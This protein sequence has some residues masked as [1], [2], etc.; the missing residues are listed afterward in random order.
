[1]LLL[2]ILRKTPFIRFLLFYIT[3]IVFAK[4]TAFENLY[5][6]LLCT[7]ILMIIA[8][9]ILVWV[10]AYPGLIRLRISGIVA[11]L[12]LFLSG[13]LVMQVH[14][15][16][17]NKWEKTSGYKGWVV[18]EVNEPP[19]FHKKSVSVGV[20]VHYWKTDLIWQKHQQKLMAWFFKDSSSQALQTGQM[21]IAPVVFKSV[22]NKEKNKQQLIFQKYLNARSIYNYVYIKKNSWKLLDQ[23]PQRDLRYFS[24]KTQQQILT[25][26]RQM[27]LSHDAFGILS[28]ITMGYKADVEPET[29]LLFTKAG[30]IHIM[31]LSGFNVAI[32]ALFLDYLLFFA[33][34]RTWGKW[35]RS[36]VTIAFIWLFAF[37]TG[38]S[39]SV[40][41]ASAMITLVIAGR[42][43]G[44]QVKSSNILLVSAFVL[45]TLNPQLIEDI[46]FQLS[47]T[48]VMGILIFQPV[49]AGLLSFQNRVIRSLWQLFTVSCAAQLATLPLTIYYFDQFPVYFWLTNL[50]AI[51]LVS[52]IICL[53]LFYLAASF[54]PLFAIIAGKVLGILLFLLVQSV[55]V[56]EILPFS[57]IDH[58]Q[59]SIIQV[60]ILYTGLIVWAVFFYH[61]KAGY[62]IAGLAFVIVFQI[63]SILQ[64]WIKPGG[65]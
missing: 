34:N 23:P 43:L 33:D 25:K 57:I 2:E 42:H 62:L 64:T 44:R 4:F 21:F 63:T 14:I 13:I 16:R 45:L 28:A 59:I 56:V 53:A 65:F 22:A 47:F 26:Y 31:A 10:S 38:L 29:K 48:A 9:P 39:P 61:R 30:V 54:I 35:M 7:G 15:L 40:N 3:G 51:P 37:I 17:I 11:A 19:S 50:Y 46:S 5:G 24:F 52:V 12:L 41:R 60:F 6:F 20:T 32:I 8:L 49:F 1:M 58:I 36:V 27:G 18:M 55:S